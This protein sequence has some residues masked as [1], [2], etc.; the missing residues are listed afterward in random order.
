MLRSGELVMVLS[1]FARACL[2]AAVLVGSGTGTVSAQNVI[3]AGAWEGFATRDS[4]GKFDR[5]VLYNRTIEALTASPSNML[6]ITED[7]SGRVGFMVFFEP[8]TLTRAENS[9][10][11]IKL[12][13]GGPID[14]PAT[15]LS[16]F[17]AVTSGGLSTAAA[18][19]LREAKAVD[20]SVEGHSQTF[21]LP[22][23]GSVLDELQS[24]VENNRE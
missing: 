5:C 11:Q 16:D 24:C 15:V 18:L 6:G 2:L 22:D 12:G 17:H 19:R 1:P 10:L 7:R 9:T 14:L 3:R 13:Q 21:E 8:R 20:V 23:V 4:D